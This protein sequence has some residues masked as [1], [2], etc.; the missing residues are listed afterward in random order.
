MNI[1]LRINKKV[2][3]KYPYMFNDLH[4]SARTRFYKINY[5]KY[6]NFDKLMINYNG[7]AGNNSFLISDC[8]S[9]R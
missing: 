1:N 7:L 6:I 2:K 8:F 5:P 3:F 9:A 4:L